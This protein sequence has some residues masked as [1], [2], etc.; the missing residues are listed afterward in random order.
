VPVFVVVLGVVTLASVAVEKAGHSPRRGLLVLQAALL[1]GCLGVGARFGPFAHPDRPLAV[2]VGMLAVAAMATQSALV[3][4]ALPGV[5][6]TAVMTTNITQ[7]TVDLATL[8]RGL[9]AP[10]DLA[11]ARHR[12]NATLPCVGGFLAG[13]AAGAALECHFGLWALALPVALAVLA[14]PLG[15]RRRDSHATRP[16]SDRETSDGQ[17][18]PTLQRPSPSV[19]TGRARQGL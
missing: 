6:S 18:A 13:C 4:V 16:L 8:A 11:R 2:L 1:A 9:G 14:V 5:P 17:H 7:L 15:E 3:K 12:A 10:D 19:A